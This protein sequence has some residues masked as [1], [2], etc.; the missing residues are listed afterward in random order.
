M[1]V[2]IYIERQ[3]ERER[4]RKREKEG[5]RKRQKER[6]RERCGYVY[7]AWLVIITSAKFGIQNL[8]RIR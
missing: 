4:E 6:E 5:E 3:R 2:D 1:S 7:K 8:N